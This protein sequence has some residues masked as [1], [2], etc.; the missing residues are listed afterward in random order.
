[1]DH[2]KRIPLRRDE[3]QRNVTGQ[4]CDLLTIFI[5]MKPT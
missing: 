4:A 1:M 3:F 2:M 5:H